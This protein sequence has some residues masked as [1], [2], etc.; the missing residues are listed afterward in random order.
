LNSIGEMYDDIFKS[1]VNF[2][3]IF[4]GLRLENNPSLEP[5]SG[6]FNNIFEPETV[7]DNREFIKLPGDKQK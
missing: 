6:M 3:S 4:D 7:K 2:D 5:I 1:E